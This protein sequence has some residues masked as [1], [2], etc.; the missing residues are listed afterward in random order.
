MMNKGFLLKRANYAFELI[1]LKW[2][3]KNKLEI[4]FTWDK[5]KSKNKYLI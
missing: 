5:G 3:T 1:M 4:E 2:E